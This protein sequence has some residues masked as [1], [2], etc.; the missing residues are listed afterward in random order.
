MNIAVFWGAAPRS[1]VKVYH[2]DVSEC[3]RMQ[4][5]SFSQNVDT[6]LCKYMASYH[7]TQ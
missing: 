6:L 3:P 1:L 5:A 2:T 4:A 7:R